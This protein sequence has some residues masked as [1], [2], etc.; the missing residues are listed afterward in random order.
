MVIRMSKM[1][2]TI[3]N[4]MRVKPRLLLLVLF[5]N[6]LLWLPILVLGSV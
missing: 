1:L 5:L 3:I 2:I 4:S 6:I